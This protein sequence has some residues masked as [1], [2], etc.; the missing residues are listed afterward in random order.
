MLLLHIT[1]D[2]AHG[3]VLYIYESWLDTL[4]YPQKHVCESTSDH[5][6]KTLH[7]GFHVFDGNNTS[8][9]IITLL[10]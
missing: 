7:T 10:I 6:R 1:K 8:I 9:R 2:K 3:V 5:L 4:Y